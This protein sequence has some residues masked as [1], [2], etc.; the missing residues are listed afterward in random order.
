MNQIDILRERCERFRDLMHRQIP[1]FDII[2]ENE[3]RNGRLTADDVNFLNYKPELV[4]TKRDDD[5][6]SH[7]LEY[8]ALAGR[9]AGADNEK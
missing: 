2:I 4:I 9:K 7:A 5:I 1:G 3:L 8:L 6:M